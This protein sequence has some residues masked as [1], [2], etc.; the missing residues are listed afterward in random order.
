MID[1]YYHYLK[2][3]QMNAYFGWIQGSDMPSTYVHLSGR[4]ID[5]AILKANGIV[6]KDVST[7][8]VLRKKESKA[9]HIFNNRS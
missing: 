6:Q 8:N 4:D 5:D 1:S 2:E 9:G 3:T 7:L